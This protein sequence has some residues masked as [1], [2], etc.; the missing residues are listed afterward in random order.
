MIWY[1]PDGGGLPSGGGLLENDPNTAPLPGGSNPAPTPRDPVVPV[2]PAPPA[3]GPAPV[4]PDPGKGGGGGAPAFA[5]SGLPGG[6]PTRAV[7]KFVAP[8]FGGKF[9]APMFNRP[10]PQDVFS[11]PGYQFRVDQGQQGIER[12]AAARGLLRTGGTLK[13][14]AEYNQN[15]ASNEYGNEFNRAL[16]TFETQYRG[17]LDEFKSDLQGFQT[18]YQGKKDEYAPL[19]AEWQTLSN[20]E[21]QRALAAYGRDTIWFNPKSGGGGGGGYVEE[22]NEEYPT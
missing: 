10:S 3:P 6:M 8:V 21:L 20:A 12:S 9:E 7:P 2:P 16:Q 1:L 18:N 22:W 17:K 15:F 14:I 19:L 5:A 13:D 4:D 11:A